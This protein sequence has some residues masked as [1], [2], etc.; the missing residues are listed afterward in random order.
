[1]TKDFLNHC[2]DMEVYGPYQKHLNRSLYSF[3]KLRCKFISPE[4]N[5]IYLL[6]KMQFYSEKSCV[7]GGVIS[8]IF[9]TLLARRYGIFISLGCK[10]GLGLR[11]YHPTSIIITNATIG[12]N[13]TIFQNCTI[14]QKLAG[15]SGKGLVPVIGN[16]CTMYAGSQI[17][18]NV[19]IG[20]NVTIGAGSVV[21][22]D[23]P[24][25]AVVVGNPARVI[26]K[27]K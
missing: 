15:H 13:F 22:K 25:N 1:M 20:N 23:I 6:R 10:I 7:L 26:K 9:H 3:E 8:L 4:F 18:G 19:K 14:G 24:D 11:I 2:L 21:L 17:I 27:R 5:A 16:N 12:K